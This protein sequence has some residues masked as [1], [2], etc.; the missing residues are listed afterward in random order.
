MKCLQTEEML[1]AYLEHE[2]S[3]KEKKKVKAHLLKCKN[4]SLLLSSLE[5]TRESLAAFPELEVSKRLLRKLQTIPRKKRKLKLRFNI[6]LHPSLQP[7]YATLSIILIVFSFY[8]FHPD[9]DYINKSLDRQLHLGYSKIQTLYVG[10]SSFTESL[11]SYSN[12]F[13][14]SFERLNPWK[15]PEE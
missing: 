7:V 2:L 13:I 4:C 12:N 6:L 14:K 10:A 9:R 11:S 5:E 1:S 8:F 3:S 15:K